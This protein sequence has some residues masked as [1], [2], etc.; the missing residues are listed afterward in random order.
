MSNHTSPSN[1]LSRNLQRGKLML[2]PLV[3]PLNDGNVPHKATDYAGKWQAWLAAAR[4]PG[5]TIFFPKVSEPEVPSGA[6]R[7]YPGA[8][9]LP[10]LTSERDRSRY[11]KQY[12]RYGLVIE[13]IQKVVPVYNGGTT[14]AEKEHSSGINKVGSSTA[15]ED[16]LRI[17]KSRVNKSTYS[18]SKSR[19]RV[20][21]DSQDAKVS[22]PAK[23]RQG[24]IKCPPFAQYAAGVLAPK[25]P[26]EVNKKVHFNDPLLNLMAEEMEK[27]MK[28][29]GSPRNLL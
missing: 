4:Q 27:D 7:Y 20:Y 23:K 26:K 14:R 28:Y 11:H 12:N 9:V 16:R 8:Y 25:E 18:A 6:E 13:E 19:I 17:D 15:I 5:D 2:L 3:R 21:R 10:Y 22:L 29:F 1:T 24:P